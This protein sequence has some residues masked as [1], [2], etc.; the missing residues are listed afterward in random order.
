RAVARRADQENVLDSPEHQRAQG[1]VDHRLVVD[2]EQ[3][4]AHG[5][6]HRIEARSCAAGKDD[7]FHDVSSRWTM[8]TR[9]LADLPPARLQQGWCRLRAMARFEP[10]R[11]LITGGA[12]FI[13]SNLT[14]RMLASGGEGAGLEKVVVLD[15]LTYAGHLANL[16]GLTS[17]ARLVFVHGDICDRAVVERS[18]AE[19]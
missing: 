14:R 9:R 10:R 17:D 6:R 15:A 5:A 12:G 4:L 7:A 16:D 8:E 3:L 13:G 11:L 18:V 19:H 1:V 2:R